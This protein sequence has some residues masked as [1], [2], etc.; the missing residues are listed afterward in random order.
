[1]QARLSFNAGE[2]A[3]E[4]GA[5]A[6][7]DKF[8]FGCEVLENWEVGQL[9]GVRRRRGMRPVV[10][11][12][13][14][15]SKIIPYVYSYADGDAL[16]FVV[17]V[18]PDCVRVLSFDGREVARF[19]DGDE[20]DDGV[21]H[22][23]CDP[24]SV[25]FTQLN[26]LLLLTSIWHRPMVLKLDDDVWKFEPWEFKHQPWRYAHDELRDNEVVVSYSGD[27]SWDV[28]FS[29]KEAEEDTASAVEDVDFL[30]VSY[31]VERQEAVSHVDELL[32]PV[33]TVADEVPVSANEGD[34]F[35][36]R[37]EDGE[38]YWVC[39][40]QQGFPSGSYV[41][42]LES[43][44]NY[45]N[46]FRQADTMK[47]F[48]GVK[49]IFSLSEAG[50]LGFGDKVV[51]KSEYWKYFTCV[52][53]YEGLREGFTDFEDYPEY[54]VEGLAVGAAMSCRGKWAFK[55]SGVWYGTYEVRRCYDSDRLDG[56]W[57]S[58]GVSA[59][60]NDSASN[61]GIEG[62]EKEEEC[63]LRLFITRSR[64][65][66]D[67]VKAGFPQDSCHNRLVVEGYLHDIELKATPFASG[68]GVSWS[69]EDIFVP[70]PGTRIRSRDWSW[71][72]FSERYG[73]PLL[74]MVYNQRLVF[75]ST[76]EQPQ[77]LWMSRVDDINNFLDGDEDD[78]AICGLTLNTATQDPICWLKTR[79]KSLL[80]GTTSAEYAV[81]PGTTT[82]GITAE[83]AMNEVHSDRGSDEQRA[84]SMP[85]RVV[86]VSRGAKR[87]YEFGYSYEADGYVTRDLSLLAP[88]IARE[89][90]GLQGGSAIEEP[91]VVAMFPLGDGQL[92]LCTYNGTQEVRAW[93]RWVTEGKIL[94]V[95]GISDGRNND[96]IFLV[97][98]RDS[99][100][101][102][103][104]VDDESPFYDGEGDDY[105]STLVTNS[106]R[107]PL[108]EPV[109]A[110]G[111]GPISLC[112]GEDLVTEG[113]EIS[114]DG[115]RHWC[116]LNTVKA[117]L[118]KGWHSDLVT[119]TENRFE[120]KV[121]IR[122]CGE[123]GANIL[124]IQA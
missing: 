36:V 53:T 102:I 86:F 79:K 30:R 96:K 122:V 19:C 43:P 18:A 100:P 24:A 17:E 118:G 56:R 85:E 114:S 25:R 73:F 115:G 84:I 112:F 80:L 66:G 40:S 78:A 5:R 70:K 116:G 37:V 55:C 77:T 81:E 68:D 120:R 41:E 111:N 14:S 62:D 45:A 67:N 38:S 34:K 98:E 58:R 20:T 97:V 2:L 31:N 1:M 48:D 106:L 75:A 107:S 123:R 57:E 61:T 101:W 93:H 54:F 6:D 119:N 16:R 8:M 82:G 60:Y 10:S 69:C 28:E 35:A 64:R 113:V 3:P 74:A 105:V 108:E 76:E 124:A 51:I 94:D 95:C 49:R 83:N 29:E 99:I 21:L 22:F 87:A 46:A 117:V 26:K 12:I 72:A 91:N 33:V 59:S 110:K 90:G 109:R 63:Y 104:V 47:G 52:K 4:L 103:E 121:G 71:A 11:A 15:A 65:L 50:S 7:L 27:D 44:A 32:S 9:G 88:H 23:E 39:I 13:S 42:G 92:A 89:H